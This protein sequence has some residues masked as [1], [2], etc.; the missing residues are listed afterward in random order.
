MQIG[1]AAK[2]KIHA[3]AKVDQSQ[4]ILVQ[5]GDIQINGAIL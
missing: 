1:K 4:E 5:N 3:H 2:K